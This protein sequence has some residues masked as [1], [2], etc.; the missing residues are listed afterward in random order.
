MIQ[1]LSKMNPLKD[2]E[3]TDFN[4][5]N[6]FN[7]QDQDIRDPDLNFFND[8]NSNNFDRSCVLEENVKRNLCDI[9]KYGNSSLF[10]LMSKA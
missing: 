1:N 10:M 7:D 6:F 2:F 9:E 4:L 5:F 3:Q 8:L